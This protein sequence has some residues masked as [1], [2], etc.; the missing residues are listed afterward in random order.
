MWHQIEQMSSEV[1]QIIQRRVERLRTEGEPVHTHAVQDTLLRD[2]WL[3]NIDATYRATRRYTAG[4][5]PPSR[6]QSHG[7]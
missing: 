1:E 4:L 7:Q 5:N 6:P 2:F 3:A